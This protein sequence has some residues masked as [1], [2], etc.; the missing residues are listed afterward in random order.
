MEAKGFAANANNR[1]STGGRRPRLLHGMAGAEGFELEAYCER[2]SP[3]AK[4]RVN[5]SFALGNLYIAR[6]RLGPLGAQSTRSAQGQGTLEKNK[7]KSNGSQ[8]DREVRLWH[9]KNL[10]S[11]AGL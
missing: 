5:A 1:T 8:F 7:A 3:Q 2:L 4:S 11:N 9:S 10:L 6:K